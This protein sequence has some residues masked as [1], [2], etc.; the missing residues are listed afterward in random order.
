[1]YNS[2]GLFSGRF[3]PKGNLNERLNNENFKVPPKTFKA[4][5]GISTFIARTSQNSN[6]RLPQLSM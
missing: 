6:A 3:A 4:G 1:V 2:Y 5:D